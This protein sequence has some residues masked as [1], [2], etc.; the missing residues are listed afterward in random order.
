MASLSELLAQKGSI[1]FKDFV[2][3]Q[4]QDKKS[5]RASAA[6]LAEKQ[7]KVTS[8]LAGL[9]AFSQC[10]ACEL[11]QQPQQDASK[12]VFSEITIVKGP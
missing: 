12:P 1:S 2:K 9:L 8:C 3:R 10:G 6:A 4:Q 7:T 11:I 5:C